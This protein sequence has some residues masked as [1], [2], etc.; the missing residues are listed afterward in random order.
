MI[1][2]SSISSWALVSSRTTLVQVPLEVDVEEGGGAAQRHRGAVLLLHRGEVAEVEPLHGLVGGRGG[3][4]DVTAVG[5]RHPGQLTQRPYLLG[6]FLPV[7]DDV[8]G[9][10]PGV[11]RGALG[12]LRLDQPVGAVQRHAPVVADDPAAAVGVG[13]TGDDAD[14]AGGAHG[15]GVGVEDAV[16]VGLAVGAED[17]G[18]EGV[19]LVAVGL[20]AVLHHADAAIGH[21]RALERGVGLESDDQF[22]VPV[23]VARGVRGDRGRGGG[24]HVEDTAAALLREQR[25][26]LL[27]HRSGAV[28]RPGEEGRVAL[29]RG[30][31]G[32][33]EVAHVDALT[34]SASGEVPPGVGGQG[35]DCHRRG[36]HRS[37]RRIFRSLPILAAPRS[38]AG[39]PDR[40]PRRPRWSPPTRTFGPPV[41]WGATAH[42][43]SSR[44]PGRTGT[45]S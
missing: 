5:G 42:G 28:R 33:D 11:Q 26:D 10:G 23:D 19:G 34:P 20:Q 14:L 38:G 30:V 29:V 25:T 8:G 44:A 21:D 16:V 9:G 27:P 40:A 24:V 18:D 31:V 22:A 6:E 3:A 36:H 15:G 43:Q 12:L 35:A 2:K 13:Q 37:S 45:A 7:T 41:T 39:V 17:L 32:L 1:T 4:G